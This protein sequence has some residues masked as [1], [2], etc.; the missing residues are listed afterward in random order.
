M[1]FFIAEGL[2][3]GCRFA[4]PIMFC[5]TPVR[6]EDWG[7]NMTGNWSDYSQKLSGSTILDQDRT[8]NKVNEITDITETVGTAWATPAYDRNGNTISAPKPAAL[9]SSLTLTFDAWNRLVELKDGVTIKGKR[10]QHKRDHT[11]R[12]DLGG[13]DL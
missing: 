1:D 12:N 9:D 3:W 13:Q 11:E 8:H 2:S 4:N 7:I 5:G 10:K 6:E